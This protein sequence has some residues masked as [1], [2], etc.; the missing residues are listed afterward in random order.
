MSLLWRPCC[1]LDFIAWCERVSSSRFVLVISCW[2]MKEGLFP[3]PLARGASG[4]IHARASQFVTWPRWRLSVR[5]LFCDNSWIWAMCPA[6][7]GVGPLFDP[8][9]DA[10]F[11]IQHLGFRPT[12]YAVGEQ[13][14]RCNLTVLWSVR[15]LEGAGKIPMLP[16]FTSVT[17]WQCCRAS[18]WPWLQNIRLL[19]F[20]QL[21]LPSIIHSM[22]GGVERS[23]N[24]LETKLW[25]WKRSCLGSMGKTC[26]AM[27][28]NASSAM[29]RFG[30]YKRPAMGMFGECPVLSPIITYYRYAYKNALGSG[31]VMKWFRAISRCSTWVT[32]NPI[33]PQP[34]LQNVHFW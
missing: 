26:P 10:F 33:K 25:N 23:A 34:C 14:M 4:I 17:G 8:C 16:E 5:W 3:F 29:S 1:C 28:T 6:G 32:Q 27:G 21:L 9:F 20:R 13:L 12:A 24:A 19:V 30:R 22:M 7:T 31:N 11:E 18:G 15:S 2:M